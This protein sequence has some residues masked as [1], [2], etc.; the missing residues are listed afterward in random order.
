MQKK[1]V[2]SKNFSNVEVIFLIIV[3]CVVSLTLGYLLS[4]KKQVKENDKVLNEFI[5]TY[6]EITG[7]YYEKIDKEE[8]LNGAVSGML[9]TL[10]QHSV[11]VDQE[12]NENFYLVLN[13]SYNGVGIE[14][15]EYEKKIIVLGVIENS[16]AEKAGVKPGDIIKKLDDINM[17]EATTKSIASYIRKNA[18]K[19]EFDLTVERDEEELEFKLKKEKVIITSVASKII[20]RDDKKIGYI[21]ISIFS[22]TTASQF[23]KKL[24]EFEKANIDGLIIDVRENSGGHLSTAV[25]M[26][27]MLLDQSKVMYQTDKNGKISKYH[28]TGKKDYN[29][30]IIIIQNSDSA[31][32]SELLSSSLKDNLDATIVGEKSYGKGTV[33]EYNYL[34][35]GTMYKYTTKKWLTPNGECIDEV[36][37]KP[38][39]EVSL[40]ESYFENPNDDNDNQLNTAIETLLEK[41]EK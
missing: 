9:S 7:K 22:N 4:S 12:E 40:D 16:P 13:G 32:A 33:Q 20:E 19:Q 35:N 8:L 18:E 23:S 27:S 28:S 38:D 3:T 24:K 30:P 29:K 34:S 36:G 21:Y 26:L 25:S 11:L 17:D 5:S 31:S 6:K 10:D 39:V 2:T 15:A 37:V 1:K 41:I 14:I